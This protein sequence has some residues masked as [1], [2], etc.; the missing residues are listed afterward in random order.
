M[1]AEEYLEFPPEFLEVLDNAD[2]YNQYASTVDFQPEYSSFMNHTKT[3]FE[4]EFYAKVNAFYQPVIRRFMQNIGLE[5]NSSYLW[6]WWWQRY[7]PN[8]KEFAAHNHVEGGLVT[9]F[10]WCHFVKPLDH[11]LFTWGNGQ[12][13]NEKKN[14]LVFFP[15]WCYHRVLPNTSDQTR[16]TVAGNINMTQILGRI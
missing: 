4:K 10:S 9:G 1:I 11:G 7:Q 6:E 2:F 16:L 12:L 15:N 14:Q 8:S 13:L 5:K 3:D